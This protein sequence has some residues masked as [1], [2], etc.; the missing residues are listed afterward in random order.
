ML[1]EEVAA[2]SSTSTEK[3]FPGQNKH[4]KNCRKAPQLRMAQLSEDAKTPEGQIS[5]W[6][7]I[8]V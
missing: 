2:E 4:P 1:P 7:C 8:P 5:N 3:T 6:S